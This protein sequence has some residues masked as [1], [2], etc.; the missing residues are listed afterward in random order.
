MKFEGQ[1]TKAVKTKIKLKVPK[2]AMAGSN[3]LIAYYVTGLVRE[4]YVTCVLSHYTDD[5]N[6]NKL[7]PLLNEVLE[8]IE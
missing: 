3:I 6:A 1:V 2:F 7:P 5:V 8:L 4:K